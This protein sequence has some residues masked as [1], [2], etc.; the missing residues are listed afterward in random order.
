MRTLTMLASLCLILSSFGIARPQDERPKLDVLGEPLPPGVLAR[1][2]GLRMDLG[3]KIGSATF[4]ADDN[5]LIVSPDRFGGSGMVWFDLTTGKAVRK[6]TLPKGA[7]EHAFTPDESLL[8]VRSFHQTNNPVVNFAEIH[9]L[10]SPTGK[11]KWQT[12]PHLPFD[13][14]AVSPDG[15]VVAGGLGEWAGKASDVYLWDAATGK[16][17]AILKGHSTPIRTLAFSAGGKRLVSV[18]PDEI[19]IAE[20]KAVPGKAI[21]WELPEGKLVKEVRADGLDYVV[22]PDGRTAASTTG[23]WRHTKDVIL[24]D[25]LDDKAI[26]TLPLA[27]AGYCFTPDGKSL[28]TGSADGLRLWDARTG[29][30]LRAFKAIV[31]SGVRPLAFSRNGTVLATSTNRD[32]AVRLWDVAAGTERTPAA[33]HALDIT[34]L[35]FTPD[36]KTLVS[37]SDDRTVRIWETATGKELKSLAGHSASIS[38]VAISP[39]GKTAVSGDASSVVQIWDAVAGKSLN[40]IVPPPPGMMA[41]TPNAT[42][43][44]SLAMFAADGKTVWIGIETHFRKDGDLVDGRG[45][46]AQY[47]IATGKRLRTIE[48]A[49]SAPRAL[50]PD[51]SLSVW[52]QRLGGWKEK[53]VVRRTGPKDNGDIAYSIKNDDFKDSMLLL[54][55][56]FSPDGKYVALDSI[57]HAVSFHRSA[58]VPCFRLIDAATGEDVVNQSSTDYPWI[59]FVPGGPTLAGSYKIELPLAPVSGFMRHDLPAIG[60]V[61]AATGRAVGQLPSYPQYGGPAAT[62]PNAEFLATVVGNRTILAWDMSKLGRN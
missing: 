45:E 36:G 46:L 5:S 27:D 8:V 11:T 43:F 2:G 55:A 40:R 21:V 38:A 15:K 60:V 26:A 9:V 50:S 16:Q 17:L 10:E 62:S 7:C 4:A 25:L 51:A 22:S 34:Q 3:A 6:L 53:I 41:P 61:D 39:D 24:R 23:D 33:G 48:Q 37:G 58:N 44:I 1:M 32:G 19:P 20:S 56:R 35:T 57:W 12:D 31:G 30:D 47:D 18:A 42:T 29:R 54:R 52:T 14:V 28:V 49:D 13:R 59:L